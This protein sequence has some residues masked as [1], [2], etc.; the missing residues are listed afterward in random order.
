MC[1]VA[2][3]RAGE[4]FMLCCGVESRGNICVMLRSGEW[5]KYLCYVAEWR[6]GEIYVLSGGNICVMLRSGEWGNEMFF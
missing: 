5:G 3:W 6:V 4:I 2:E 1:Y